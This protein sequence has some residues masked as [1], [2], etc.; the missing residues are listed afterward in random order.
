[1]KPVRVHLSGHLRPFADGAAVVELRARFATA[2]DVLEALWEKH[3]NLRDRVSTE[4]GDL[5]PHVNL[6]VGEECVRFT[7]GLDTPV[8]EGAE[9]H[10]LPAVSGG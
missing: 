3:P 7:G 1:V 4:L 6:F 8:P 2:R 10:L 9:L 5:R